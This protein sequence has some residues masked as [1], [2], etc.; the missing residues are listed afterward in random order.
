MDDKAH[1]GP[2]EGPRSKDDDRVVLLPPE[3]VLTVREVEA[4]GGLAAVERL[5]D[6]LRG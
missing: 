1:G 3:F 4:A 2:I 5:R 6:Q